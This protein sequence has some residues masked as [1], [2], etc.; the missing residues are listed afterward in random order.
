MPQK[1]IKP[2]SGEELRQKKAKRLARKLVGAVPPS[3]PIQPK[4]DRKDKHKKPI[5]ESE[6]EA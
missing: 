4:K 3:R 6:L 2:V 1:K 5:P